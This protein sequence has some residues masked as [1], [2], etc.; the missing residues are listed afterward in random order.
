VIVSWVGVGPH[1]G[2]CW[3]AKRRRWAILTL[4]FKTPSWGY[5]AIVFESPLLGSINRGWVAFAVVG[6]CSLSLGLIRRPWVLTL[7]SVPSPSYR[8][9]RPRHNHLIL[10]SLP[11]PSPLSQR[12]RPHLDAI[13]LLYTPTS[14]PHS[15]RTSLSIL[16][17]I[18]AVDPR[19]SASSLLIIV[20]ISISHCRRGPR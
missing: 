16:V 11:S 14:F 19:Q 13:C 3:G 18:V 6:L 2:S 17:V 7:V 15:L 10:L 20:V 9:P 8:S 1:S 12:P 4:V 5:L